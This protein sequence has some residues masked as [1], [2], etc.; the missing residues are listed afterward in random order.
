MISLV[1]YGLSFGVSNLSGNPHF[2]MFL[3]GA[4]ELP[5]YIVAALTL[6][7]VGRR[8]PHVLMMVTGGAACLVMPA[9]PLSK[10]ILPSRHNTLALC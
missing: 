6:N 8:L 5:G 7:R 1:Y 9:I 2:N 3:S 10:L 4:L